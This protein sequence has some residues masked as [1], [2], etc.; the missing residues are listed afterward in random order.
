MVNRELT[1]LLTLGLLFL[2]LG[3]LNDPLAT[4]LDLAYIVFGGDCSIGM[5]LPYRP[6][7]MSA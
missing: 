3:L 2:A 1:K 4:L 6:T 5:L 7:D